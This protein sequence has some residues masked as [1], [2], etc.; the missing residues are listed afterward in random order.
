MN[1]ISE[2]MQYLL[3]MLFSFTGDLGVSII[4]ITLAIKLILMPLSI[5]QRVTMLKQQ[6]MAKKMEDI[7]EKYKDNPKQLENELQKHSSD[8]LKSM[9]GCATIL[10]QMPIVIALYR[11]FINMP[12]NFSSL[13][14][15]WVGSLGISDSL[16]IIPCIY[17]MTMLAPSLINYIPYFKVLSQAKLSKTSVVMTTIMSFVIT[18]KTP[19]AIGIY[20]ITSAVYSFI[21]D[22]CFKVYL[23]I[24]YKKSKN[25]LA[26]Q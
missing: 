20:F 17:A 5:K 12:K 25:K 23:R 2:I 21:E 14:V 13:V 8:S 24:K 3:N 10:L 4:I 26:L 18:A 6:D 11:T 1:F 7:K 22:I 16:F 19:V 9:F 15:P